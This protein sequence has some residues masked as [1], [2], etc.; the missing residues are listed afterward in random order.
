MQDAYIAKKKKAFYTLTVQAANAFQSGHVCFY[1]CCSALAAQGHQ[2]QQ[3][4][5]GNMGEP[6]AP[7][8]MHYNWSIVC[9]MLQYLGM[10][11][12]PD[13]RMLLANGDPGI[14]LDLLGTMQKRLSGGGGNP[15]QPPDRK[16]AKSVDFLRE[17]QSSAK[18][19]NGKFDPLVDLEL[20]KKKHQRKLEKL[21]EEEEKKRREE[22]IFR[23]VSA[24]F[25]V[26]PPK[27]A[28]DIALIG[29][30]PLPCYREFANKTNVQICHNLIQE[31][32]RRIETGD[33]RRE[34]DEK[35]RE[36]R[37]A[38]EAAALRKE[39][40]R[41]AVEGCVV[42]PAVA[43]ADDRR[44]A[45]MCFAIVEELL[46]LATQP[47]MRQEMEKR[48]KLRRKAALQAQEMTKRA[49]EEIK[50]KKGLKYEEEKRLA[51][52][53]EAA[54]REAQERLV[55]IR[56]E[57]THKR[58]VVEMEVLTKQRQEKELAQR[59]EA[60]KERRKEAERILYYAEQKARVLEARRVKAIEEEEEEQKRKGQ[61]D[62]ERELRRQRAAEVARKL[63][64]KELQREAVNS[65]SAAAV[66]SLSPISI[67]T[68]VKAAYVGPSLGWQF[69]TPS[70]G[71]LAEL[72]FAL[73]ADPQVCLPWAQTLASNIKGRAL[74]FADDK[75]KRHPMPLIEGPSVVESLLE[76]VK[77]QKRQALNEHISIALTLAARLHAVDLAHHALCNPAVYHTGS[78]GGSS[79]S[80]RILKFGSGLGGPNTTHEAIFS[81][82]RPA[83]VELPL[84]QVLACML[85][86]DGHTTVRENREALLRPVPLASSVPTEVSGFGHAVAQFRDTIAVEVFVILFAA[87]SFVDKPVLQMANAQQH[88]IGSVAPTFLLDQ[89]LVAAH[90]KHKRDL[91]TAENVTIGRKE[92][93]SSTNSQ[94]F[95]RLAARKSKLGLELIASRFADEQYSGR[96]LENTPREEIPEKPPLRHSGTSPYS[97]KKSP[98][99][100]IPQ[101]KT[102]SKTKSAE[103][104]G[105]KLHQSPAP[106]AASSASKK[107]P[108][109]PSIE[110]ADEHNSSAA[111]TSAQP[112]QSKEEEKHRFK[113]SNSTAEAVNSAASPA[114]ARSPEPEPA[115]IA[116]PAST[117]SAPPDGN[118]PIQTPDQ[119]ASAQQHAQHQQV[120]KTAS[121]RTQPSDMHR[122]TSGEHS[123]EN[124]QLASE[125]QS[126]VFVENTPPRTNQP[127]APSFSSSGGDPAEPQLDKVPKKNQSASSINIQ[128]EE[129]DDA[130]EPESDPLGRQSQDGQSSQAAGAI[131]PQFSVSSLLHKVDRAEHGSEPRGDETSSAHSRI[132]EPQ[133]AVDHDPAP[134]TKQ[135]SS[136][137]PKGS[138]ARN[139]TPASATGSIAD[140]PP[141]LTAAPSAPETTPAEVASPVEAK[142]EEEGDVTFISEF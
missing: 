62:A 141:T 79:T 125:S 9:D 98:P 97:D 43:Q 18:Q 41:P 27:P 139:G 136:A 73:R 128:E 135:S 22:E 68:G 25:I 130:G 40:I 131:S 8:A 74:W 6:L 4:L 87:P 122:V 23:I 112:T 36:R 54:A 105:G 33:A 55:K 133:P 63:Q 71:K 84:E 113:Q 100:R 127:A 140:E 115:S 11:M 19:P 114:P 5:A 137:L 101:Q 35:E 121:M 45:L 49:G 99:P 123:A 13:H 110:L 29:G 70:E 46:D 93:T 26:E 16:G 96:Q 61:E 83:N 108:P 57:E 142:H 104:Q 77:K 3:Q 90:I 67:G 12:N 10:P 138:A 50:Q 132:S 56:R 24:K 129:E 2:V 78:D 75:G 103:A 106:A 69:L 14:I 44:A 30:A 124:S 59:L 52:E 86:D 7:D 31:I 82:V 51:A 66:T 117:S 28:V 95:Q 92:S 89:R 88:A 58:A 48:E 81:V 111:A 109:A 119:D 76:H 94:L 42:T 32:L 85:L 134:L 116:P 65:N 39:K 64:E 47:G 102:E 34:L 17:S 120:E 21:Q 91:F 72:T 38:K 53:R 15:Q 107:Q 1:L 20:W 37:A 126:P 60:E 118:V 80:Q